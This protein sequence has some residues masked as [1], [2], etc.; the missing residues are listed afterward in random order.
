[1]VH[2][3]LTRVHCLTVRSARSTA[4]IVHTNVYTGTMLDTFALCRWVAA[5]HARQ[6]C[7]RRVI[8]G[9]AV[10]AS[11]GTPWLLSRWLAPLPPPP[12]YELACVAEPAAVAVA[13]GAPANDVATHAA[14][15]QQSFAQLARL[16]ALI[17]ALDHR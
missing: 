10:D 16:V 7:R 17:P 14:N 11:D 6:R 2:E 13:A 1:M 12:G 5:A 3:L 8:Y 4:P 15:T 9:L